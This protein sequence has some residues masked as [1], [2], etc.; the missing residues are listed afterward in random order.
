MY[1]I[2]VPGSW[3]KVRNNGGYKTH[4]I[5]DI[6]DLKGFK[7]PQTGFILAS[8]IIRNLTLFCNSDRQKVQE[9]DYAQ[10]LSDEKARHFALNFQ[11]EIQ[12]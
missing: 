11:E 8:H 5:V 9:L 6:L 1:Q 7:R 12:K 2:I 4:E 3:Y 10:Y